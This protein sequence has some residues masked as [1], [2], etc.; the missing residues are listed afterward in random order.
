MKYP[1][2]YK[3]LQS[4]ND[5]SP[6]FHMVYKNKIHHMKTIKIPA[7]FPAAHSCVCTCTIPWRHRPR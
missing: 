7:Y 5:N 6:V 3:F 4:V 2:E 1:T